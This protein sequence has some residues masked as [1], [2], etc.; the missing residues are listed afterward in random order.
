[1]SKIT[2]EQHYKITLT[3]GSTYYGRTTKGDKRYRG[4]QS[5]VRCNTHSNKHVQESYNKYGY[6]GWVH[7]WLGYETGDLQHHNKIEF[8]RVQADP[9]ALNIWDGK[10]ALLSEDEQVVY[11]VERRYKK[12]D[13]MT[14][15]EGEK[16]RQEQIYKTN[17]WLESLTPKQR[18]EKKRRGREYAQR[19]RDEKK[20]R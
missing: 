5:D 7:E 19:K 17:K 15:K 13:D 3:D 4:H 12:I 2:T 11:K 8:G 1:M 10:L 6:D 20:Q 18:E 14:P 9:K 16:Y